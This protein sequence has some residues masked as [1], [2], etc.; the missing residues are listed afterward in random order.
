MGYVH[1]YTETEVSKILKDSEGSA[2]VLGGATG[3]AEGLHELQPVGRG[4]ASTSEDGLSDRAVRERKE[5]VGAFDGSQVTAIT[6]ALNTRAGQNT[7][8]YLNGSKV[9]YVF[10]EIDVSSQL[11]KMKT[12]VANVPKAFD[13]VKGKTV[14][15]SGPIQAPV[16]QAQTAAVVCLKLVPV[17][18]QLHIRTAFPMAAPSAK[19]EHAECYYVADGGIPQQDIPI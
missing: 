18:G 10:A 4:R 7:L 3:H 6:W 16:I 19:G 11:F 14:K 9:A 15:A 17:R 13:P 2:T 1:R 5:A 8:M 12:A